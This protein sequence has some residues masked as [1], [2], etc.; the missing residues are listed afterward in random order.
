MEIFYFPIKNPANKH[1]HNVWKCDIEGVEGS[2]YMEK[3][4]MKI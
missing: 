3:Q 2:P 1:T 4:N